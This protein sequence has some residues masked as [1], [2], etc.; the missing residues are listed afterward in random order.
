MTIYT[1]YFYYFLVL[2]CLCQKSIAQ[3]QIFFTNPSFEGPNGAGAVPPG[4]I[5]CGFE[6]TPDTQPGFFGVSLLP[7]EGKTFLSLVCKVYSAESYEAV[8]QK[9][10]QSLK[11]GNGYYFTL[12]LAYVRSPIEN[13]D[14]P[15]I[16]RIW[17]VESDCN[18]RE[19]LW[20]S[21]IIEHESWKKYEVRFSPKQTHEYILFETYFAKLPTY[22]GRVLYDNLSPITEYEALTAVKP[23]VCYGDSVV[24]TA[25]YYPGANYQWNTLEGK[26]QSIMVKEPGKYIVEVTYNGLILTGTVEV[27]FRECEERYFIPNLITP[28]GDKYNENFELVGFRKGLWSL[29]IYNRWGELVYT[30]PAYENEWKAEGLET[31]IYYYYLR[32]RESEKSYR[33]YIQVA[34]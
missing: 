5:S 27:T 33:G 10:P 8:Y 28:N 12:D 13:P 3:T 23:M 26:S 1:K 7:S 6:S 18:K 22:W 17:G 29:S 34:R 15:A 30:N 9:L 14:L 32:R 16:T 24:V 31:G 11:A 19:L 4:W 21:P 20:A 25:N 2:F